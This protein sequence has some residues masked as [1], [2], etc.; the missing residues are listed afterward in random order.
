MF[1]C[2]GESVAAQVVCLTALVLTVAIFLRA[3]MS[4]FNLDPR[5]PFIQILAQ[6]TDPIIEPIRRIMPRLGMFDLSPM[7]AIILIRFVSWRLMEF[8]G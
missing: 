5:S 1:S 8:F 6:L 4:W 7:I 3:I 2:I